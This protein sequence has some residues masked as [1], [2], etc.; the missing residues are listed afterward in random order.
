MCPFKTLPFQSLEVS[1]R[2]IPNP[3]IWCVFNHEHIVIL[4]ANL[5]QNVSNLMSYASP[6]F[7]YQKSTYCFATAIPYSK[8]PLAFAQPTMLSQAHLFSIVPCSATLSSNSFGR[9]SQDHVT[10]W[11]IT[12]CGCRD[13]SYPV[14][15]HCS[16]DPQTG[17]SSVL[18]AG[19]E[20][21]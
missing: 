3:F 20:E 9:Q 18:V 8:E 14:P 1:T 16:P 12:N 6:K 15:L 19:S 4:N 10:K 2:N 13:M 17:N 7:P 11:H 5:C 21:S